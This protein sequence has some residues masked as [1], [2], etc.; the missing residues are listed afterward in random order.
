MRKLFIFILTIFLS[1]SAFS[2]TS[3]AATD[4]T[5]GD[6]VARIVRQAE[7]AAPTYDGISIE[8][9]TKAPSIFGSFWRGLTENVSLTLTFDPNKKAEKALKFSEERMLIAEKALES[10][11]P[12]VRATA[13]DNLNR[14]QDLV[15]TAQT[16]QDQALQK[17][18][19][20]TTRLLKNSA[21]AVDRQQQIFDRIEQK[22][23]GENLDTILEARKNITDESKGLDSAIDNEKIPQDVR[24]HL[25][26]VKTRIEQHAADIQTRAAEAKQLF[27]AAA[28][29][30]E[31][32]NTK[33]EQFKSDRLQEVKKASEEH[34]A[35]FEKF[36]AKLSDLKTSAEKGD[37][38]ATE[39]LK[40][41]DQ[42]PDLKN[43]IEQAQ[44]QFE[45]LNQQDKTD[46][47]KGNGQAPSNEKGQKQNRKPLQ[48]LLD[49]SKDASSKPS[50]NNQSA[51][52]QPRGNDPQGGMQNGGG[53]GGGQ[54]GGDNGG[55]G[56]F[57]GGH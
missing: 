33:L 20:E 53:F 5:S 30:D 22:S 42:M 40:Q 44:K 1:L 19:E 29:G 35:D 18:T 31:S 16:S 13:E 48:G 47:E 57:G 55:G 39:M 41:I 36:Q 14:A 11:D 50:K 43:R 26:E 10:S 3:F 2:Q 34:Q 45:D 15:K 23:N 27:E 24:D 51:E 25:K 37:K 17:P 4:A 38:K 21:S 8:Q 28:N 56:E 7:Q 52:Q 32:A 54:Q 12:K 46:D 49:R 9:P 6:G